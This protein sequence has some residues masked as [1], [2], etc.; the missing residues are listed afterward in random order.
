MRLLISTFASLVIAVA[1]SPAL[2]QTATKTGQH[3]AW[4]TYS[5]QSDNGPVCYI[6]SVP[7]AF[8]PSEGVNHGDIFFL[9]SNKP[10]AN[11][12]LEPSFRAAGFDFQEGSRVQVRVG[13]ASFNMYTQGGWAWVENAADEPRLVEAMKAGVDMQV[14]ARSSRPRDVGYTFSLRGVT[15]ALN[16][17]ANCR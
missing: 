12:P 1:A 10:S 5:Y 3:N 7:T 4:A 14:S 8:N 17:I 16:A 6:S 15:A 13:D 2:A 9:I 11:V